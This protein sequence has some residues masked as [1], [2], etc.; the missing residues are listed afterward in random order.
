MKNELLLMA[1]LLVCIAACFAIDSIP[2][3][4]TQTYGE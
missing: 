4:I 3:T 1:L 2:I